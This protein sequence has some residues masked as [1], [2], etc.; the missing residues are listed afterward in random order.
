MPFSS[1]T[2]MSD[3]TGTEITINSQKVTIK[4]PDRLGLL[5]IT[6]PGDIVEM[7]MND[8]HN[9]VN[10]I[11]DKFGVDISKDDFKSQFKC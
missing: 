2:F 7:S 4:K 3:Y 5:G 6:V 1:Q 10:T 8:I 9:I 11:S